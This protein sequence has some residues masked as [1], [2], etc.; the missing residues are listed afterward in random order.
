[1]DSDFSFMCRFRR[2]AAQVLDFM[3]SEIQMMTVMMRS[4]RAR[5]Q[6]H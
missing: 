2:E 3:R 4:L 6:S 5:R 1:M